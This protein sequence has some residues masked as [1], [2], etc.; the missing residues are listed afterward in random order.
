[1]RND[2]SNDYDCECRPGNNKL[3]LYVIF[4][5]MSYVL[6]GLYGIGDML[7]NFGKNA[8]CVQDIN[9]FDYLCVRVSLAM[10][11]NANARVI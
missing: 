9:S 3:M 7:A 1:M 4:L 5:F 2:L 10:D 8:R 6:K 11:T